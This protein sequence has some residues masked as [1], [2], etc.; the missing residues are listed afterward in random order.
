MAQAITSASL[1]EAPIPW[2]TAW[3]NLLHSYKLIW[4]IDCPRYSFPGVQTSFFPRVFVLRSMRRWTG[5]AGLFPVLPQPLIT[6]ILRAQT[7]SWEDPWLQGLGPVGVLG[8]GLHDRT[9]LESASSAWAPVCPQTWPHLGMT[10]INHNWLMPG[11]DGSNTHSRTLK[12]SA[13]PRL[14]RGPVSTRIRPRSFD[15]KADCWGS[16]LQPERGLG[17]LAW[18]PLFW[19]KHGL[20]PTI[21]SAW[22]LWTTFILEKVYEPSPFLPF[23]FQ[24]VLVLYGN[25]VPC[26]DRDV[27][28][29]PFASSAT[30][31]AQ[32][33]S[34]IFPQ[35]S[36]KQMRLRSQECVLGLPHPTRKLFRGASDAE[37]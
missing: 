13:R 32:S 35:A 16:S 8:R 28:C 34:I 31:D 14:S 9:K 11:E 5:L 1:W 26:L 20:C 33:P 21:H 6:R 22:V 2:E 30:N 7:K 24:H 17:V 18:S 12:V 29:C 15:L 25:R 3:K 10:T 27:P 36:Q 37:A 23:M 19:N 4:C